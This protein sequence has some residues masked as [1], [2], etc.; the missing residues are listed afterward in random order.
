MSE[1]QSLA[2]NTE[3]YRTEDAEMILVGYGIVSRIL[4]SIVDQGRAR[5]MKLGLF[6]S[7]SLWPFSRHELELLASELKSFFVCELSWG[8]MVEDVRLA[9]GTHTPLKFLWKI[10][11]KWKSSCVQ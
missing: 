7:V 8:Q 5:D 2:L 9:V 6:R 10:T 3:A 11:G 1:R 4:R